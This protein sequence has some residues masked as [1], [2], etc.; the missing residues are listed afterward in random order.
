MAREA[1]KRIQGL[2]VLV[3]S[4]LD[5]ARLV[6]ELEAIDEALL[7]LDLRQP[8]AEVKMPKTSRLMDQVILL[9]ELNLLHPEDR[10]LLQQFL[11]A[12]KERAPVVHM[13][14]NADPPVAFMEKLVAWL[15]REINPLVLVTVGLQ[16][17]M[18]AGCML[19]TTNRQFDFSLRQTFL[20]NRE[21]LISKLMSEEQAA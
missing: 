21:L 14:F 1:T 13:S 10:L 5:V 20:K 8:G 12:V 7:Q 15:R 6:R 16:P 17:N 2:P 19:R 18:G 11:R 3:T 9:N 4:P